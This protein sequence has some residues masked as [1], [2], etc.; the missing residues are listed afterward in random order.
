M[1]TKPAPLRPIL[2]RRYENGKVALFKTTLPPVH[3][4]RY[5]YQTVGNAHTWIERTKMSDQQ[6]QSIIHHPDVDI[7]V[8]YIEGSPAGYFELDGREANQLELAYFGLVPEH[9]GFGLGAFLLN[10]AIQ[11]A[12][13]KP[14]Q[15]LWVHTNTLDH[16]RALPNYQR[17]GFVPYAQERAELSLI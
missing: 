11:T 2:P 4:Y 9:I 7:Y 1:L 6:L 15:R 12:W 8:L 10:T 16:P 3:Y 13:S 17:F 14:I 5:L